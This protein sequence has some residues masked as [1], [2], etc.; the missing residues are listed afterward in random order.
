MLQEAREYVGDTEQAA[1][2][3]SLRREVESMAMEDDAPSASPDRP[4]PRPA[5]SRNYERSIREAHGRSM[6]ALGY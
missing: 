4:R 2:I 6:D 1:S 3:E 5:P